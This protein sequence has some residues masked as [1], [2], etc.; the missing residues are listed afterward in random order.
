MPEGK[1]AKGKKVAMASDEVKKQ[2][3]RRSCLRRGPELWHWSVHP[4]QERLH[5][6]R[7]VAM[8]YLPAVAA[9][10]PVPAAQGAAS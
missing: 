9:G 1:K 6:L 2:E 8:P 5:T 7:P 10:H 3:A 4:A